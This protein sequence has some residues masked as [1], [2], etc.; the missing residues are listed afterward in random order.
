MLLL[1]ILSKD[2]CN[3]VYIIAEIGQN[4]QGSV[5]TA[6]QMI[7][8]AKN[9]GCHC[10]KFQKSDLQ[11]KFTRSAL[12][13]RYI[14]EHAWGSTY[15]EHKEYL[16]FS[17]QQYKELQ[18]YSKEIQIDFT[19]SAMDERSLD[20]LAALNVPF[21][22]I[23][24][25]DANNFPLLM[26]A[27]TLGIPLVISTGMQSL[28]T[29]DRIVQIMEEAGHKQ[30]AL[31]H[32]VSSYPTEAK[33][34]NLRLIP[35]LKKRYANVTIGYSGHELGISITKAAVLSGARII[36]RHFTLDK[37]QKG[38]DHRCSLEPSELAALV[39]DVEQ[40]Q[41][42]NILLKEVYTPS[43]IIDIL[44]NTMEVEQALADVQ[45]K[46]ILSCEL[47]CRHKLGKSIVAARK[48]E[49]GHQ[50][51]EADLLIKVSEPPGIFAER[52]YDI[53]G[54]KL[55]SSVD[56]DEPITENNI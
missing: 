4:H 36:E 27:A 18:D 13:R 44:G 43:A 1:D 33:D 47:P 7:L 42:E 12:N 29:V 56:E 25:G 6:K 10:V 3:K 17:E 46:L 40:L 22:K 52:Y 39:K 49:K 26:K 31:L 48:L 15:G 38:S 8:A 54:V 20:F 41:R 23:G 32:C 35:F 34:C 19:A 37:N 50:L 30:Y 5:E 11:A 16:E 28:E 55:T 24:S 51:Q 14:S 9:A 45:Q 53:I 21:I 2:I